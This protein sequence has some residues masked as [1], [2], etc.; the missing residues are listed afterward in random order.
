MWGIPVPDDSSPVVPLT[1]AIPSPCPRAASHPV[2][3]TS[4]PIPPEQPCQDW[5]IAR[6]PSSPGPMFRDDPPPAGARAREGCSRDPGRAENKVGPDCSGEDR[7]LGMETG[8]S[9]RPHAL[10][11]PLSLLPHSGC[12]TLGGDSSH[13]KQLPSRLQM[14][15]IL[16]W[17]NTLGTSFSG[18]PFLSAATLMVFGV[19]PN[20]GLRNSGVGCGGAAQQV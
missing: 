3:L 19:A 16:Q 18:T 11:C 9:S 4:V 7:E 2:L 17:A 1:A 15:G 5:G 10:Q 20:F 14:P 8:R 6:S 13:S 12:Y